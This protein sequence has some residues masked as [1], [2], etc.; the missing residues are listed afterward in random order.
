[1]A[2]KAAASTKGNFRSILADIRKGSFAPVYLLMGDEPY[3]ID[4]L[5]EALEASVVKSAEDREFNFSTFYGQDA[6][7]AQVIATCQQ[8]PFMS[9]RRIVLLKEAQSMPRGKAALDRLAPYVANPNLSCVLVVSFKGDN[10]NATSELMKVAAKDERIIVYKSAKLR[11]YELAAPVSEYAREKKIGIDND[12]INM[13]LDYVGQDLTSLF[14]AIDK[15]L[16][17]G[18]SESGRITPD[19]IEKNLR[20]TKEF[21]NF[22]LQSAIARKDYAKCVRIV[23]SYKR[24]PNANPVV[25][26]IGLLF[27]FFSKLLIGQM[28]GQKTEAGLI[29]AMGL[30]SSYSFREYGEAMRRYSIAQTVNAIHLLRELDVKSKGVGSF[31]AE[32]ALLMEFIFNLF[33]GKGPVY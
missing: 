31:Q 29:Q 33:A 10:L 24:N 19:M 23:Q 18:G 16:I 20:Q 12:T 32:H 14:G 8:Y 22:E 3:Y 30:K 28:S 6:D 9:E 2:K 25:V 1:M 26:T 11:D 21:S 27:G 4:K 17:A 7:L 13:L 15:L 5:V